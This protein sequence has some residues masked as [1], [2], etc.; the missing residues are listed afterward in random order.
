MFKFAYRQLSET[1]ESE[2]VKQVLVSKVVGASLG[3]PN[4]TTIHLTDDKAEILLNTLNLDVYDVDEMSV[5]C[6]YWN[7]STQDWSFDGCEVVTNSKISYY[8]RHL[9]T[10]KISKIF[11]FPVLVNL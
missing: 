8:S 5:K 11:K 4:G 10:K 1:I 2:P 9:P 6:A 3:Q 7:V